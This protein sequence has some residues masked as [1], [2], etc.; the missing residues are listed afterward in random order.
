M[1]YAI[2]GTTVEQVKGAGGTDIKEARSTG[3]VFATLTEEQAAKLR[4]QGCTVDKVGDIKT[5]VMPPTPVAGIPTYTPEQLV[6]IVGLEDL[7]GIT[8][9]P[10]YGESFNLAIVGT[11]IRETHEKVNGHVVYSKNYT[12]DPV[13]DGFDHDTGTCSI[14]VTVA[15]KCNILNLK[16][17]DDK[18]QGTEE[19][20]VLAIDD[21]ISLHDTKPEIAPSV[22][23]LSLGSPD[24]GNPNNI[25]RVACRAAIEKGIWVAAAAG[26]G[27]PASGTIMTPACEKYVFAVGSA[28]YEPFVVSSFS[29]RGPTLEGLVKPDTIFFGEDIDMASSKSDTATIAKSGTSFAVP[30]CSGLAILYQEAMLKYKGV[31]FTEDFPG[32]SYPEVTELVSV[33]DMLDKYLGEVCVKPQGAMPGKDNDNGYGLIYGLALQKALTAPT[34]DLSSILSGFIVMMGVVMMAKAIKSV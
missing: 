8:R 31:E 30:F 10:L 32:P 9:P 2:I 20:V 4:S 15:P 13:G 27:G 26:N 1:R 23:N 14:A 18:G 33:Q 7:R 17:L 24:D 29:S 5:A 34:I 6:Q 3:I 12:S 21:C 16:V 25:L 28:K 22:I 11:G 19:E